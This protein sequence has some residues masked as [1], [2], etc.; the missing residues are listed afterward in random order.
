[1]CAGVS[2]ASISGWKALLRRS[3]KN[4]IKYL[5][6][7]REHTVMP[8]PQ[9]EAGLSR[10]HNRWCSELAFLCETNNHGD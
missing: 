9:H 10:I 1:M 8:L 3:N 6:S 5:E 2:T 7:M 4:V